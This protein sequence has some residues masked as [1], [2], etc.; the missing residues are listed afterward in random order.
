MCCSFNQGYH[1]IRTPSVAV[2]DNQ[3]GPGRSPSISGME[4]YGQ[5]CSAWLISISRPAG[6]L[7]STHVCHIQADR[8]RKVK[9]VVMVLQKVPWPERYSMM[10]DVWK[11]FAGGDQAARGWEQPLDPEVDAMKWMKEHQR[12]YMDAQL[13][14]G[15]F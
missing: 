13:G 1:S 12:S 2:Y 4:I 3:L 6:A 14:S 15:C 5:F 8:K 11:E 10:R 7:S 9:S